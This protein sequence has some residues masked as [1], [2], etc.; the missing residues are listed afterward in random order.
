MSFTFFR[1]LILTLSFMVIFPS[2]AWANTKEESVI[3]LG[4]GLSGLS[5]AYELQKAGVKV[6][7]LSQ[8]SALG[9][10]EYSFDDNFIN[11]TEVPVKPH[12]FHSQVHGYLA[13][14]SLQQD[15]SPVEAKDATLTPAD[16]TD[17]VKGHYYLNG[18]LVGFHDLANIFA[19]Q[20]SPDYEKFWQAF[21]KLN[22]RAVARLEA[23]IKQEHLAEQPYSLLYENRL[24]TPVTSQA[25]LSQLDLHPAAYL[26]AKHHLEAIYGQLD[27]LSALSLAQQQKTH[28]HLQDRRGQVMRTMGGDA[29]LA[30]TVIKQLTGPVLL[31][32]IISNVEHSD[33]RVVVK[34]QDNVF[35]A[36]QLLVT[37]ALPKLGELNFNPV[38]SNKLLSSAQRLN[39]GAYNKVVLE[40]HQDF[41][42]KLNTQAQALP[43][44]FKQQD[45]KTE[46]P[47]THSLV[48]FSS[49][50]LIEGQVY[51]TQAH[52][53]AVKRAQLESIYPNSAQYFLKASVEAWHREPWPGG[54]YITD[55]S[56]ALDLYW[57]QFKNGPSNVY[58]A[59]S[60]F[61]NPQPGSQEGA[62]KAGQQVALKMLEASFIKQSPKQLAIG[63]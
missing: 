56:H 5:A 42:N 16:I 43:M 34:T 40:Y 61:N 27:S 1:Q 31:Q 53:I 36:G 30:N 24:N 57:N 10:P 15:N 22:K 39:Y 19:Q 11:A 8:D 45:S 51:D 35:S 20:I 25:W 32:Q 63:F 58:F 2:W 28:N 50:N 46:S 18:K 12:A 47:L 23:K 48:S 41:L 14:F 21:A 7:V 38:L 54:E 3:V 60:Q 44:G 4:S 9:I 62:L 13:L 33:S 52:L 37:S 26:L 59:S 6:T 17:T 55:S 49:G 29:F